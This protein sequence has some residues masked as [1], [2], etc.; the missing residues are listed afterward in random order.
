LSD[1]INKIGEKLDHVKEIVDDI[2]Y[3]N[4]SE[5]KKDGT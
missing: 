4:V 3:E 5:A 2:D 1:E